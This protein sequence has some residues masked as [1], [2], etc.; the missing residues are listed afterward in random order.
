MAEAALERIDVPDAGGS[1][2]ALTARAEARGWDAAF[3]S[4]C[5][6]VSIGCHGRGER[7]CPATTDQLTMRLAEPPEP[8]EWLLSA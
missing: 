2:F 3:G 8:C 4:G 6:P 5:Q 7:G 1:T